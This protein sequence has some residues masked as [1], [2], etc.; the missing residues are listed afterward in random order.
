MRY[1]NLRIRN[2]RGFKELELN[3]FS[4]VNLFVGKNATGKTAI[5]ESIFIHG[6]MYNPESAFRVNLLCC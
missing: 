5:L 2:F 3:N 6:G 1:R 4:R